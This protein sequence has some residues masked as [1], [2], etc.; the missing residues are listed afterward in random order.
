MGEP[1]AQVRLL[2]HEKHNIF[3][4]ASQ[5][6]VRST[7]FSNQGIKIAQDIGLAPVD[8]QELRQGLKEF[9]AGDAAV[10]LV[11]LFGS[12]A[13]GRAGPGSDY[14]LGILLDRR[15]DSAAGRARLT[16]ELVVIL[17]TTAVDVVF[18]NQA[19]PELA[20]AVI[21]GQVLYERDLATRVEYEA[22]VMGR[23]YDYLPYLREQ[24]QEILS[25]EDHGTRIQRYREALGR[26]E[27]TL[28]QIRAAQ[29]QKQG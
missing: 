14:D 8:V 2:G 9:G 11:Y 3:S 10:L 20:F 28:G 5:S 26:T 15:E 22:Y 25:G 12:R 4:M 17:E 21:Q 7:H 19:P 16:H 23:Y 6:V 24:R 18:L 29:E 27:R 13:S 1:E